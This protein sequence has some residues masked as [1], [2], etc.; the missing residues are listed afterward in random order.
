MVN[1]ADP[2][3]V[4]EPAAGPPELPARFGERAHAVAPRTERPP[5]QRRAAMLGAL[6][7]FVVAAAVV[8]VVVGLVLHV[9]SLV[10]HVVGSYRHLLP[11][12]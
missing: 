4:T 5:E 10:A 7:L 9:P 12:S 2:A 3:R 6:L 1:P 8:V 11:F